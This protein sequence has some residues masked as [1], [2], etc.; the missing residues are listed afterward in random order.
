MKEQQACDSN[1]CLFSITGFTPVIHKRDNPH[2]F[3]NPHDFI[4]CW[5]KYNS[6]VAKLNSLHF[7]NSASGAAEAPEPHIRFESDPGHKIIARKRGWIY[8][9]A[10]F[11]ISPSMCGILDS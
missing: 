10:D 3:Y 11:A 6:T 4:P 5:W 1:A 8:C 7:E 2:S 9:I